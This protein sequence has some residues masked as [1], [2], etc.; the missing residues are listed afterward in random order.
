MVSYAIEL[1]S[2]I[3]DLQ[4]LDSFHLFIK[5]PKALTSVLKRICLLMAL[6]DLSL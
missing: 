5:F 2:N 6:A 4:S 3:L 1:D